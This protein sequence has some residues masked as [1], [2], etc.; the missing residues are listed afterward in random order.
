MYAFK[1]DCGLMPQYVS[2]SDRSCFMMSL[3]M[4]YCLQCFVIIDMYAF[5]A[6]VLKYAKGLLNSKLQFFRPF[7]AFTKKKPFASS[8]SSFEQF[9][10]S[11]LFSILSAIAISMR[12]SSS[13]MTRSSTF[14]AESRHFTS[15]ACSS[16]D[17]QQKR[18]LFFASPAFAFFACL[19]RCIY[20]FIAC[21][22]ANVN[23]F[24][25]FFY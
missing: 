22:S 8:F 1:L 19:S 14:F 10:N 11:L 21:F 6:H 12:P 24:D 13:D 7:I 17:V 25:C 3:R 15:S 20:S 18:A 2:S 23:F 4:F 9:L 5:Q 16:A